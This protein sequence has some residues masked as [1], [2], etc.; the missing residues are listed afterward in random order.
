VTAT[1]VSDGSAAPNHLVLTSTKTGARSS[2]KVTLAG[3]DGGAPDAALARLLGSDPAGVQNLTQ[4]AAAQSTQLNVN[5]IAVTSETNTVTDAIQGVTLNVSTTGKTS[6]TIADDT[7]AIKTSVSTFVKAYNDLNTAIKG[8]SS[9]DAA[10]KSAGPLFGD[11]T[12][13][14]LQNA[15]R[16]Q[17]SKGLTGLSGGLT[18]LSQVGVAFQ[19]DGTLA[20]DSSKLDTAMKTNLRDIAGLFAVVGSASDSL[21]GFE[22]STSATKPGEYALHVTRLATQGTLTGTSPLPSSTTILAGTKWKVTLD[23]FSD[24]VSS[25]RIATVD[26]PAGTYSQAQ[27]AAAIQSAINGVGSFAANGSSVSA[28]VG[29]D[30]RLSVASAKYGSKSNIAIES[31]AGTG[32]ATLFGS[33]VPSVGVDVAGTIGGEA[34]TGVG[35]VLTA[36]A[37]SA[38]EGL[39]VKVNGGSV[40]A[41]RGT[42]GFSQGYAYQLNNIATDYV[43]SDGLL[44]DRK[45]GLKT[46]I[47]D[48]GKQR[49]K[50]TQRLAMVEARYRAQ[51]TALDMAISSMS[52]TSSY[53]SQQLA[54][55]NSQ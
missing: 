3:T 49:D 4:S 21:V 37:G 1:I 23:Q 46:T 52:T 12:V 34:A 22:G 44:A 8:V 11:P 28:T 29:S 43:S 6:V 26:L 54:R 45:D 9:Y 13:R 41:D 15:L 47:T 5:G 39:K 33:A 40:P 30:G 14:G 27:L 42:V 7:N 51:Y 53:L 50:L 17:F 31:V 18:N 19:K 20:L 25:S 38:A 36:G 55:L 16:Q 35:Q 32:P 2:M 48:I 24:N 10:T